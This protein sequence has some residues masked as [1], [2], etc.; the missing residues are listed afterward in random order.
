MRISTGNFYYVSLLTFSF[1]HSMM[2]LLICKY[3]PFWQEI[4]VESL[5]LRWL[6]RPV[7]LLF[8][9]NEHFKRHIHLFQWGYYN[10]DLM[11]IFWQVL[12]LAYNIEIEMIIYHPKEKLAFRYWKQCQ[13]SYFRGKMHPQKCWGENLESA[14]W[15]ETWMC[16][17]L[18]GL[19]FYARWSETWM[20]FILTGLCFYGYRE[21]IKQAFLDS[22]PA[23]FQSSMKSPVMSSQI[24]DVLSELSSRALDPSTAGISVFIDSVLGIA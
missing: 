8:F 18:T 9:S 6:L 15:S 3:D 10:S 19:C 22:L 4:N 12:S 7:G 23:L 2:G 16:F 11:K 5:I 24:L 20:C 1:I 14:R 13:Q 21:D 17:I